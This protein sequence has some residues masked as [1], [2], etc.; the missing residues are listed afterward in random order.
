MMKRVIRRMNH[1]SSLESLIIASM[2]DV[3]R[4]MKDP[5]ALMR[6]VRACER[7]WNRRASHRASV[8]EGMFPNVSFLDAMMNHRLVTMTRRAAR[9]T[10]GIAMITFRI[11]RMR[12]MNASVT[13][14]NAC[15]TL[16]NP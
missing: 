9:V 4:T 12:L 14:M 13:L 10:L 11:S 16:R 6:D 3:L 7:R 1:W 15:V 2:N 5:D 8:S